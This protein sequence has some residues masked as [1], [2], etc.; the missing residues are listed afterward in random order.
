MADKR[1]TTELG[2]PAGRRIIS[3]VVTMLAKTARIVSG[4]SDWINLEDVKDVSWFLDSDIGSTA[5]TLDV[6]VEH[7]P[8]KVLIADAAG[9]AFTQVTDAAAL[10]EVKKTTDTMRFARLNFT[11]AGVT[12]SFTFGVVANLHRPGKD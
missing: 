7:S 9:G 4:V 10:Q 1:L 12:P 8:D 6:K 3:P 2:G 11:I 5:D